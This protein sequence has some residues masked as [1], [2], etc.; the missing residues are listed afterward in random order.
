MKKENQEN[1]LITIESL[2]VTKLPELQGMREIQNKLVEDNPFIE[3]LDNN[4]YEVAKQRRTALLKGRTALENQDKIIASKFTELRKKVKNI[5]DELISITVPYE[6]KQQ[7]EVKRWESKKEE[8][9]AEK[10]RL[11][12]E[13][14]EKI[15]K[16]ISDFEYYA[17]DQINKWDVSVLTDPETANEFLEDLDYDFE[18]FDV[19]YQQAKTRVKEFAKS[20]FDSIQQKENQRIENERLRKEKEEA[21]A[22]LKAIQ[23]QQEKEHIERVEKELEEKAKVFEVRKNR[24]AEIGLK[25]SHE[26]DTY[27]V[28]NNSEFILIV[29]D[30]FNADVIEFENIL[31]DA[32]KAIE[33]AEEKH[34]KEQQEKA[35]REKAEIEAKKKADA[36][37]KAR[38]KR[39]SKDKAI[40]KKVLNDTLGRFPI[41]FDADQV[42]VREFSESAAVRVEELKNQLLTELENL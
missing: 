30:I 42:E 24:L 2:D 1:N 6:E 13:R 22:K 7:K 19:L 4:S 18:E 35:D 11:E 26:H 10:E 17:I 15:K 25:Y 41:V 3:I 29:E 40:Y 39:L 28:G 21:D 9:K 31:T 37:N 27:Y 36:E 20:K 16:K 12:Q 34:K 5:T 33:E 23:D 14:I 8:E 38:V 32:K